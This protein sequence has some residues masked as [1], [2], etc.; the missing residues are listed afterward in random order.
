MKKTALLIAV[1][2]MTFAC[3]DKG[4]TAANTGYDALMDKTLAIH[5]E[6]MED[7]MP[8]GNL[9]STLA[10]KVDSFPDNKQYRQ[11]LDKLEHAHDF[12][13][14]W[15]QDFGKKFPYEERQGNKESQLDIK[16]RHDLLKQEY[17]EVRTMQDSVN[18]SMENARQVLGS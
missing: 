7:M 11:A 9:S 3:K 6:V 8:L 5:D 1:L 15:M 2:A 12:M 18:A 17:E 10:K 16:Q 14:E 13:M 4:A